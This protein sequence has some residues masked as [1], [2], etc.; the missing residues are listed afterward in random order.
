MKAAM[1]LQE[2]AA[3]ITRQQSLKEDYVAPSKKIAM[4]VENDK[5]MLAVG[6]RGFGVNEIAHTQLA[7]YA[8]IPAKY[9]RRMQQDDPQLLATNV[10]RWLKD[11]GD[12]Q[13]MLRVLAGNVRAVLSGSYRRLDNHDAAEVI[14]PALMQRDLLILSCNITESRMYIKAVDRALE[15]QVPSGHKMGDGTHTIFDA[16]A[17]AVSFSNSEVGMGAY[18]IE[19]GVFTRACTNLATFGAL[20]RKYHTGAR[21]DVSSEV[22]QMLSDETKTLTDQVVWAQARDL[23]GSAFDRAKFDEKIKLLKAATEDQ[24]KGEQ[25]EPVIKQLSQKFDLNETE[26]QGILADLIEGGDLS[27]Y[28]VHSAVTLFSQ[29]DSVSYDR[30]TELERIGGKIIELKPTEWKTLV[31]AA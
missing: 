7:T 29:R 24:V 12:E 28:G 9:Y 26:R 23:I 3:E 13:R 17:A 1:T 2:L 31:K 22:Y 4:V 30:A 21:A 16:V 25:V 19:A 11:K 10:N 6:D 5:P 18:Q 27:R 14:L 8:D 20:M 15:A